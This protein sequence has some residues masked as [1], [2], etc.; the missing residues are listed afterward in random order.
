MLNAQFVT[1]YATSGG[2]ATGLIIAPIRPRHTF[3]TAVYSSSMA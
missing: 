1:L 2:V 3:Q